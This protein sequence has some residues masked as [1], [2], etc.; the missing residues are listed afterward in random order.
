MPSPPLVPDFE[1]IDDAHLARVTLGDRALER[2][3]LTL[4]AAQSARLLA[5]LASWPPDAAAVAHTLAGSARAIGAFAAAEA[6]AELEQ[7]LRRGGDA[8]ERLMALEMAV[9]HARVAI[10]ERLRPDAPGF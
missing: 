4:F 5:A 7:A 9:D 8:A 1:P 6:A 2:E 10:D 3:V